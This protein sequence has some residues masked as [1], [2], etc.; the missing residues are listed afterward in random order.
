MPDKYNGWTNYETWNMN[1]WVQN[2]EGSYNYMIENKP[3]TAVKAERIGL[4]IFP[5]G[6]P[7]MDTKEEMDNVNW[8]E[9]AEA[10]NE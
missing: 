7:D 10:W 4:E 2:E 3:Y 6:T 1:L 5:N 8:D 9:I